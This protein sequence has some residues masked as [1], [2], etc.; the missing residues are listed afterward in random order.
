MSPDSPHISLAHDWLVGMRG[1]EWVLD[2]LARLFGPTDLYTLVADGRPLTPSIDACRVIRSPLQRFPGAAGR[3]RRHYLPLYRWAVERLRVAPCDLL[4]STSSAVMK[5][6]NPPRRTPHLCYCHAPA[7][8][9]WSQTDEYATGSGGRLRR[10]GLG[11]VRRRF[12]AWDR[13]SAVRVTR[14][15]ANSAHTAA[16]IRDCYGREAEVVHPPARVDFFTPDPDVRREPWLLVVAALEPYKRTHL[17]IDAAN[18]AGL[19]LKVVGDGTQRSS[20]A[21]RAGPTVEM[22]GR[23]EDAALR[24][25]YRRARALVFPQVEDFGLVAVEAQATGCPVVAFAAGGALETVTPA[26]GVLFR[27]ASADALL[28]AIA[29]LDRAPIDARSCRRSAERFAP[30]RFD[31]AIARHAAELLGQVAPSPLST[32]A[33]S[34][35][36]SVPPARTSPT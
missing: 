23:V 35:A 36:E 21:A 22:L 4:V 12:Q 11:A 2:R 15:L 25:L 28:E 20:L 7:R 14:F 10:L 3:W 18:R 33:G 16:M 26:S 19:T 34:P 8:Y 6:I 29:A 13:A 32:T 9:L 1:G 31:A 24:G 17:A 30:A 5:S 27:E